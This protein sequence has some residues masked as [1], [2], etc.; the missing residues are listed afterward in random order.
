MPKFQTSHIVVFLYNRFVHWSVAV[1]I[2]Q[3]DC[4]IQNRSKI[5]KL[6]FSSTF[7]LCETLSSAL[8]M[9]NLEFL[10]NEILLDLF[11]YLNGIDLLRAFYDHNSRFNL[12]LYK[13]FQFYFLIQNINSILYVNNIYHLFLIELVLLLFL[14]AKIL[15]DK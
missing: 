14:T 5:I 7:I 11:E 9:M 8:N 10:P 15:Q 6:Y 13:Q 12:L 1:R 3:S 2:K 4:S